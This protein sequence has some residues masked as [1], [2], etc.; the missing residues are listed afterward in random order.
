M[1]VAKE[2]FIMQSVWVSHSC[3]SVKC[4]FALHET[5]L[6][7]NRLTFPDELQTSGMKATARP[8]SSRETPFELR[9]L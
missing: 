1:C 3:G 9:S 4:F 2:L 6:Y 8:S 7:A 5:Q